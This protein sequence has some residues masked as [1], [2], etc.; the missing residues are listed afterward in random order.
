MKGAVC[1]NSEANRFR[2]CE[3]IVVLTR[4]CSVLVYEGWS[5]SLAMDYRRFE[6]GFPA[7]DC[8]VSAASQSSHSS[9]EGVIRR[10]EMGGVFIHDRTG[11]HG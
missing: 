4:R 10:G 8:H 1:L 2:L 11:G 7:V 9:A 5:H 6:Q 3:N